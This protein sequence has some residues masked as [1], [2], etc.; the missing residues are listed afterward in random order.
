[1]VASRELAMRLPLPLAEVRDDLQ[2]EVERRRCQ[3]LAQLYFNRGT[4]PC[5]RFR[6]GSGIQAGLLHQM[7]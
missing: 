4:G 2:A 6:L 3:D 1:M 5:S 7:L